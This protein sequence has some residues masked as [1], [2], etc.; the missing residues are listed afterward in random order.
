MVHLAL[1]T[2]R[3]QERSKVINIAKR[4]QINQ[5]LFMVKL[6]RTLNMPN[7][8]DYAN[9]ILPVTVYLLTSYRVSFGFGALRQN[10]LVMYEI[11]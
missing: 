5:W 8:I 9:F 4:T 3:R 10:D 2:I 7:T 1:N 11:E 6:L